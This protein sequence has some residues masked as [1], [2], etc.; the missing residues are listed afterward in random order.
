MSAQPRSR[1]EKHHENVAGR[2]R[3]GGCRPRVST[4]RRSQER[5]RPRGEKGFLWKLRRRRSGDEGVPRHGLR[6]GRAPLP[7]GRARRNLTGRLST[8]TSFWSQG[9]VW[10]TSRRS[11]F[12]KTQPPSHRCRS[13]QDMP[14]LPVG[15][16]LRENLERFLIRNMFGRYMSK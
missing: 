16:F 4:R 15:Q 12:N 9:A 8:E 7:E 5:L 14:K 11:S 6:G 3:S 13:P 10:A 2:S 1:E